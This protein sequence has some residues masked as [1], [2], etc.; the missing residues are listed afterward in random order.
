[1]TDIE[2]NEPKALKDSALE[3]V[4]GGFANEEHLY[5]A[6][7]YKRF[8]ITFVHNANSPDQFFY[9]GVPITAEQADEIVGQY[10]KRTLK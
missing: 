9:K 8:G 2:K 3:D 4:A 1:M 10:A 5:D 6:R 7:E